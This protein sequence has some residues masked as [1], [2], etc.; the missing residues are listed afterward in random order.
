MAVKIVLL[1]LFHAMI[2]MTDV[3][4]LKIKCAD[5]RTMPY[6]KMHSDAPTELELI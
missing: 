5:L 4:Q 3:K 1:G 6:Q 2:T